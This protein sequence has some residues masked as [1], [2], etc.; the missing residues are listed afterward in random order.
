SQSVKTTEMGGPVG[1]DGGKKIA[2][3]KR[4]VVVDTLGL[5]MA[6][7]V[8][9]ANLDDGTHAHRGLSK[10]DGA[11]YPPLEVVF[12]GNKSNNN[13]LDRW[14]RKASVRYRVEVT[15]KPSDEPGFEPVKIRW[16]VEQ[17]IAC[18]NRCRRLSKDYE[19]HTASAENWVRV[20]AIQR[21]LRRLKP[22]PNYRQPHFK[23]PK[24]EKK[25][26]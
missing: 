7:A 6:V 17:S 22:D 25:A 8:T 18:L 11:A 15:S 14:R 5:L 9:A 3:R 10:V 12:P 23:Y 19:Y 2:G 1:Y 20:S 16:V 4:H 26:A 21:M 13:A 24:P